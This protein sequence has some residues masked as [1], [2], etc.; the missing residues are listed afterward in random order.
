MLRARDVWWNPAVSPR[1]RA[2][3]GLLKLPVLPLKDRLIQKELSQQVEGSREGVSTDENTI[4]TASE[5]E[6]NGKSP[7]S[8]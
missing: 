2:L 5:M 3:S 4:L 8:T 6:K 7:S 1:R